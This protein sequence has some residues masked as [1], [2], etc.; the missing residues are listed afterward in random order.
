MRY[1]RIGSLIF[2]TFFL[3]S[4]MGDPRREGASKA[5]EPV[6]LNVPAPTTYCEKT[7]SCSYENLVQDEARRAMVQ[8]RKAFVTA[9]EDALRRMPADL[10]KKYEGCT[11][12]SCG[13]EL[14]S[15]LLQKGPEQAP[16]AV[17]PE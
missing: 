5:S 15:C 16:A 10:V 6:D 12:V 8:K 3:F 11:R 9:C 1:W 7:W 13:D 17:K 4:C 2:L 14:R